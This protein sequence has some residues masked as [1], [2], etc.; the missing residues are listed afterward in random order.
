[1]SPRREWRFASPWV[2]G[3]SKPALF[4]LAF[5]SV[6]SST[7]GAQET[8]TKRVLVFS[9]GGLSA[10]AM[11]LAIQNI[12]DV[13][14]A[15]RPY[16]I[17]YYEENLAFALFP[18]DASQRSLRDFYVHKYQNHQP[19]VIIAAGQASIRSVMESHET[20]FPHVPIVFCCT[21]PQL[22]DLPKLGNDFTGT[23]VT[24][25]AAKTI[26]A[27][28]RFFMDREGRHPCSSSRKRSRS[29]LV[30]KPPPPR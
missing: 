9:D 30:G 20:F 19:D 27:A 23:W 24:Y 16:H 29:A 22:Y 1:M 13:L 5:F 3:R 15:G 4:A 14:E 26:D 12:H 25:D 8:E 2:W 11:T 17:E 10:P 7:V 6:M 28:F 21:S 18:D